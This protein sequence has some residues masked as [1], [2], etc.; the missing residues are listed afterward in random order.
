MNNPITMKIQQRMARITGITLFTM[1][2]AAGLGYGYAFQ[3][4][5]VSQDSAQTLLNL[6]HSEGLFR[7]FILSF[8]FILVLDVVAAWSL[9]Y[10]FRPVDRALSLLAACFR[11]I[12]CAF[13]A[14]SFLCLLFVLQMD[15]VSANEGLIVSVLELFLSMWSLGLLLIGLHLLVLAWLMF[16][17]VVIP[18]VLVCFTFLA[19]LCYL[20]GSL[21]DLLMPDYQQ[22]KATVDAIFSLPMALGELGLAS[23]LLLKGRKLKGD[24]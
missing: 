12:Y 14:T 16:K 1:A 20:S 21:A 9:Y 18:L 13:F 5:Y 19:A 7:F 24:M 11:L 10:C 6:Q 8:L 3:S 17:S 22:Y 15:K 4:I 23:W 2:M